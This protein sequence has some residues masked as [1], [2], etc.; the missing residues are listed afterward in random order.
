M[1]SDITKQKDRLHTALGRRRDGSGRDARSAQCVSSYDM[2]EYV[3]LR[4]I[5]GR[6]LPSGCAVQGRQDAVARDP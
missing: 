3:A 5:D 1:Y 2:Q 6:L 4:V